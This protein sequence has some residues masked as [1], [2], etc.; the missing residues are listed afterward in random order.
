MEMER[1]RRIITCTILGIVGVVLIFRAFYGIDTTDE[2]FYLSTAKRFHEGDLL[3]RNDWN[4]GQIFGLLMVPFY[5]LYLAIAGNNEG[6][7]LCSRI[8][9][10]LLGLYVS[11]FTYKILY[12][13]TQKY[14][15]SVLS[16]LCILVY[17][18]GNIITCSYYSLGF[19][20]FLL[21]ILW[22]MDARGERKNTWKLLL[23]GISFSVSV[24][25]MP[26]MAVLFPLI[27]GVG[28]FWKYKGQNVHFR[29]ILYFVMGV[30]LSAAVFFVYFFQMIPWTEL[31]E[32]F[33]VIFRDPGMESEG[34]L[35][36]LFNLLIYSL[37]VF[38]KYTWP[39]Y[40]ITFLII[41]LIALG[42][43]KNKN[44]LKVMPWVLLGEF[45]I[46]TIYVRGY[47][48]GGIIATTF[49]FISQMQIL[50][51]DQRERVL[52]KYFIIPGLVYGGIWVAGSNV[53]QRV[54]NMTFLIMN[55]WAIP[56]LW[57]LWEGEKWKK[58]CMRMP[59]YL[60]FGVQLAVPMMDIYRDV[61]LTQFDTKLNYGVIK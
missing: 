47:F 34:I 43:I 18:R 11:G 25:C 56:F 1:K 17:V 4:T 41:F 48:E 49:L 27:L 60:M 6:I 32:L 10:V 51:P 36:Q 33:P 44:V 19:Y 55:L 15:S 40:L 20:S 30:L 37:T 54:V 45:L 12:K 22:C 13:Y 53:D 21:T 59:V 38:M 50:F 57:N 9:F 52:E 5:R 26:Y 3:F 23:S 61:A 42:K 14:G 16:A 35:E 7:I 46:Q 31:F 28:I 58:K 2:T 24:L 29:K 39:I 8:C